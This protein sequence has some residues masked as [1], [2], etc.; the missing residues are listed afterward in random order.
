MEQDDFIKM[1]PLFFFFK[2]GGL[3]PFYLD[4]YNDMISSTFHTKLFA[5]LEI[6]AAVICVSL[7]ISV[8]M[9]NEIGVAQMLA[10][11]LYAI[12][13]LKLIVQDVRRAFFDSHMYEMWISVKECIESC[14]AHNIRYNSFKLIYCTIPIMVIAIAIHLLFGFYN[15]HVGNLTFNSYVL[16]NCIC[17][18]DLSCIFSVAEYIFLTWLM[19]GYFQEMNKIIKQH[20][21]TNSSLSAEEFTKVLNKNLKSY[22]TLCKTMN[23]ICDNFTLPGLF[24]LRQIM[25]MLLVH[26]HNILLK[27]TNKHQSTFWIFNFDLSL[28]WVSEY[29]LLLGHMC[30]SS[31]VCQLA[32]SKLIYTKN[33]MNVF[34]SIVML[35]SE[36]YINFK[37]F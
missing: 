10:C 30:A 20:T 27:F 28:G 7:S 12:T 32:V 31:Y 24:T 16:F 33:E 22:S 21:A 18:M 35:F 8:D 3:I 2:I 37:M 23:T 4:E 19:R 36:I 25:L 14:Q 13:F 34:K 17:I 6:F 5:I 29:L 26:S 11:T 15:Y 9:N 1:K